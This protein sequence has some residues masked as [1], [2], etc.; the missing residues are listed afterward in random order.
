MLRA[1][2]IV[3]RHRL[4]LERRAER[5]HLANASKADAYVAG[6]RIPAHP[7]AGAAAASQLERQP[8]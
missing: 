1:D 8:L 5:Q 2:A 3:Q 7:L 6:S 4:C